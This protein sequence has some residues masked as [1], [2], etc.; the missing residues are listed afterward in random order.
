MVQRVGGFRRK[1]R[2]KLSKNI[3]QKGKMSLT[4]FFAKYEEGQKVCLKAQPAYQR[5]MY[6]PRFHGK[7]GIVGSK[8]QGSCYQVVIDDMG[9][10]KAL[11]VH[12]VHLKKV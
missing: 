6:H 5:G 8:K 7:M 11:I 10:K 3:R 2:S 1:T 4:S 12:P 9:K